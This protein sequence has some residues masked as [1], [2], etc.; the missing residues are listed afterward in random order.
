M[1]EDSLKDRRCYGLHSF[2]V[3]CDECGTP[4]P[5]TVSSIA[6]MRVIQVRIRQV[7]RDSM[8]DWCP[9]ELSVQ[10]AAAICDVSQRLV[11]TVIA[12]AV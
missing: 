9:H 12:R 10:R 7:Y 11:R 1:N 6:D 2:T 4:H 3:Q 8:T 5:A